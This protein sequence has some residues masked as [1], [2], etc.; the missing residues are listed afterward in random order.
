MVTVASPIK[1]ERRESYKGS[2]ILEKV[3]C[4]F[5]EWQRQWLDENSVDKG[6][7]QRGLAEG[8]TQSEHI[9]DAMDLYITKDYRQK[10]SE[11]VKLS[12]PKRTQ[13]LAGLMTKMENQFSIPGLNDEKWNAENKEVIKIYREISNA[14]NFNQYII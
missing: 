3:L 12:E 14:R 4:Y 8:K 9:R 11:I 5:K 2:E 10:Y 7:R 13:E 6:K 1:A